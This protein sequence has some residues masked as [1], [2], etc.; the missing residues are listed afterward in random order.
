MS[1]M[2]K[3]VGFLIGTPRHLKSGVSN[4]HAVLVEL[5]LGAHCSIIV[6]CLRVLWGREIMQLI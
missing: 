2:E 6:R 5:D 3:E 4:S 1:C